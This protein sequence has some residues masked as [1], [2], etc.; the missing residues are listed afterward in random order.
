M[1]G[2]LYH[3]YMTQ[4]WLFIDQCNDLVQERCDASALAME[5]HFS[6]TNPSNDPV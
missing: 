6:C 5:L 1:K 4:N 3:N 2:A